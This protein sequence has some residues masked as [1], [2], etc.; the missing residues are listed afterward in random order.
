MKLK[1]G[2]KAGAEKASEDS[3]MDVAGE[4]QETEMTAVALTQMT[5][6]EESSQVVTE[7]DDPIVDDDQQVCFYPSEMK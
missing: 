3:Q 2:A 5:Q 4:S 1:F 7:V 6:I